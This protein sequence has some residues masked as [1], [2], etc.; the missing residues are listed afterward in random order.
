[1]KIIFF[2][3]ALLAVTNANFLR[4]LAV[5]YGQAAYSTPCTKFENLKVTVS[6]TGVTAD[7]AVEATTSEITLT[8]STTGAT[9]IVKIKCGAVTATSTELVC[10]GTNTPTP[11]LTTAE[12]GHAF[13]LTH[14]TDKE[15]EGQTSTVTYNSGYLALGTNADQTVDYDDDAKK[16]FTV[17]YAAAFADT[18][19]LPEIKVGTEVVSCELNADNKK[20]LTC[21]PNKD[22]I[23]KKEEAYQITAKNACATYDNVAKLTVTGASAFLKASLALLVAVFLF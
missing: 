9:G 16:T 22:K 13:K 4:N 12:N 15:I 18:D 17:T 3:F 21:T 7:D 20:Q 10:D 14:F 11:A 1:M 6:L 2:T 8:D 23:E 5:T 19:T